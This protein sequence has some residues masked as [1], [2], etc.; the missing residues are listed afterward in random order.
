MDKTDQFLDKHMSTPGASSMLS[1][2]IGKHLSKKQRTGLS[3]LII[4]VVIIFSS[5]AFVLS[6]PLKLMHIANTLFDFN[7]KHD[8]HTV[9]HQGKKI[10]RRI[11]TRQKAKQGHLSDTGKK[12]HDRMVNMRIKKWNKLIGKEGLSME[13]DSR[14]RF[15]GIKDKTGRLVTD[16]FR[17]K[18]F[19]EKRL[20]IGELIDD[21]LAPHRY[22]QHAL[23][24]KAL[25]LHAGVSFK[26]WAKEKS[27]DLKERLL[28]K[29]RGGASGDA[30]L[31][32]PGGTIKE[33]NRADYPDQAAYD[34]A[35]SDYQSAVAEYQGGSEAAKT[36]W[37]VFQKTKDLAKAHEAGI[38]V[39]KGKAKGVFTFTGL[40]M[41]Y[42]M[43]YDMVQKATKEGYLTRMIY[44]MR[45]GNM[46]ITMMHQMIAG[47][48]NWQEFGEMMARF[49]GDPNADPETQ[50]AAKDYTQACAWKRTQDEPCSTAKHDYVN[51]N[52]DLSEAANPDPAYLKGLMGALVSV[53]NIPGAGTVC[54][55]VNS[56]FGWVL[57]GV[58]L[59][60]GLVGAPFKAAVAKVIAQGFVGA[61]SSFAFQTIFARF[62][63]AATALAITGLELPTGLM[64][65][66]DAGLNLS[67][68]DYGR[69]M[70][71]RAGTN[72]EAAALSDAADADTAQTA[73]EKGWAY[74]TFSID[75]NHSMVSQ[76]VEH[77]PTSPAALVASLRTTLFALPRNFAMVFF[78]PK[79]VLAASTADPY[80]FRAMVTTDQEIDDIDPLDA[81][82][83]LMSAPG[84]TVDYNALDDADHD[85]CAAFNG[86][87][88]LKM[89]GDP[90]DYM[91][92]VEDDND[93]DLMHCFVN[94]FRSPQ[95]KDD[96]CLDLGILTSG[97]KANPDN[98]GSDQIL[99]KIYC[100]T[101]HICDQG[102][103]RRFPVRCDND[104]DQICGWKN[105]NDFDIYRIY[106]KSVFISR[107]LDGL[108]TDTDPFAG[109]Q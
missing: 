11:L 15:V 4:S 46:L 98:P 9:Q 60:V 41:L 55:V 38:N 2:G 26:F 22:L 40:A 10:M 35:L 32:A 52:P 85:G 65:N 6:I 7:F 42:C 18:S 109:G 94:G 3:I 27:G 53:F 101:N 88:R 63:D 25:R 77:A 91:P 37:K 64:N 105:Q 84:S 102:W 66:G 20:G 30:V 19:W 86:Q 83:F 49:D 61:L 108:T 62:L 78:H 97:G 48:V 74:R 89:L 87:T 39:I 29:V 106:L 56:W 79:K 24:T 95:D 73:Q 59:T 69:V 90:N 44:L 68:K 16:D 104:T 72:A 93:K 36:T 80:G 50:E 96:I 33:P 1:R 71:D 82:C 70:G 100:E 75:Y 76:V 13:F 17:E 57:Q 8:N 12:L 81:E 23:Y 67:A 34:K 43:M 99:G 14:N 58:E 28:S 45:E 47:D 54:S 31:D 107:A 103:T 92:N 5:F 51:Y 21:S